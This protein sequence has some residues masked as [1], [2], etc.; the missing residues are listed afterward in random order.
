VAGVSVGAV[1]RRWCRND[2]VPLPSYDLAV[3]PGVYHEPGRC[4]GDHGEESQ[5]RRSWVRVTA[6]AG[7][8]PEN[9]GPAGVGRGMPRH[10][11][12]GIAP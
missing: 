2:S 9:D 4:S 12:G 1:A 10:P 8:L 11:R 6:S 5:I 7:T 3:S